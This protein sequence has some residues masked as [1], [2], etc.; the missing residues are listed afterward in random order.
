MVVCIWSTESNLI[1]TRVFLVSY[2]QVVHIPFKHRCPVYL[3]YN[4][5]GYWLEGVLP[6]LEKYVGIISVVIIY[7]HTAEESPVQCPGK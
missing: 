7:G 4:F 1:V 3:R 5:C 6:I 2:L